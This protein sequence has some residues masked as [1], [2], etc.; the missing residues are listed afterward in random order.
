LWQKVPV[1]FVIQ[2]ILMIL[3][4]IYMLLCGLCFSK[5]WVFSLLK[6][7]SMFG[8]IKTEMKKLIWLGLFIV[9][10][11]VCI[12]QDKIHFHSGEVLDCWISEK[13]PI[14]VKYRLISDQASPNIT[15]RTSKVLKIEYKSGQVEWITRDTH[16][17]GK[18]LAL[19]VGIISDIGYD[20]LF[21]LQADYFITPKINF[22]AR[23]Y[24]FPGDI[25]GIAAGFCHYFGSG[26]NKIKLY[27]GL[28]LGGIDG[29]FF[30]QMPVGLNF[31]TK[32]GFDVKLGVS[33]F[34]VPE[35]SSQFARVPGSVY[36][37]PELGIGWR[38]KY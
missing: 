10:S 27:S 5:A 16:R 4:A 37:I 17:M 9:T 3:Q 21:L 34:Y 33:G 7:S 14:N 28:L 23:Y 29:E 2:N 12:A 25:N 20:F 38:F 26:N 13:T 22:T 32:S 30:V 15:V 35:I 8:K 31:T 24:T 11:T 18:R 6:N 19:N 1:F 36:A